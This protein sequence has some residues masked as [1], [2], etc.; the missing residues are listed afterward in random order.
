[1]PFNQPVKSPNLEKLFL[2]LQKSQ[3]HNIS[4][5]F[6]GFV[7]KE[8]ETNLEKLEEDDSTYRN[9][10]LMVEYAE[11]GRFSE[12]KNLIDPAHKEYSEM[13]N[14]LTEMQLLKVIQCQNA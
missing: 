1:M 14:T 10:K 5:N 9:I 3:W 8:F 7:R 12:A 11:M 4:A 6:A 2:Y 13:L